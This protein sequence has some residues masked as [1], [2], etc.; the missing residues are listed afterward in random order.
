MAKGRGSKGGKSE[1]PPEILVWSPSEEEP[2][3]VEGDRAT[4]LPDSG[5]ARFDKATRSEGASLNT[6]ADSDGGEINHRHRFWGFLLIPGLVFTSVLVGLHWEG[7]EIGCYARSDKVGGS[8]EIFF[9]GVGEYDL[10]KFDH[11]DLVGRGGEWYGQENC[12]LSDRN[13]RQANEIDFWVRMDGSLDFYDGMHEACNMAGNDGCALVDGGTTWI[14]VRQPWISPHDDPPSHYRC[15]GDRCQGYVAFENN[16]F[17]GNGYFLVAVEPE[18]EE[19]EFQVG[20]STGESLPT[21]A[22]SIALTPVA[23]LI[24]NKW[25][26]SNNAPDVRAGVVAFAKISLKVALLFGIVF[27]GIFLLMDYLIFLTW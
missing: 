20:V 4:P 26:K 14:P 19:F 17:F 6:S 18:V 5:G 21:L 27:M 13:I 3:L 23:L 25:E 24:A 9:D 10:Y 11:D 15:G 1:T 2:P 12:D 8:E 22:F 16:G 7:D